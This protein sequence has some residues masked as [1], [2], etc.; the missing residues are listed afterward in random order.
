MIPAARLS[1]PLASLPLVLKR[2]FGFFKDEAPPNTELLTFT[3]LGAKN[4]Y[5]DFGKVIISEDNVV[6]FQKT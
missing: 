6:S 1:K 5:C 4:Y 2:A 3:T